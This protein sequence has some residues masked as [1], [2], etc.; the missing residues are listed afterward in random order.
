MTADAEHLDGDQFVNLV[1]SVIDSAHPFGLKRFL[2]RFRSPKAVMA[3]PS[4]GPSE[5]LIGHLSYLQQ[6]AR[7]K[8]L[9]QPQIETIRAQLLDALKSFGG[10]GLGRNTG[11]WILANRTPLGILE[12]RIRDLS[13]REH[14]YFA[15]LLRDWRGHPL[16][17][18]Y[19]LNEILMQ[20]EFTA[21]LPPGT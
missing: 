9:N 4:S 19:T 3:R 1:V 8:L 18:R 10:N 15:F 6:I 5:N 11:K 13:S 12:A 16:S 2:S 20:L 17:H 14:D 21:H 7:R